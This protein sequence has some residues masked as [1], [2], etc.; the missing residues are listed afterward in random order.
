MTK[1]ASSRTHAV[2]HRW[3]SLAVRIQPSP[4]GF[5][6]NVLEQDAAISGVKFTVGIEVLRTVSGHNDAYTEV[7]SPIRT[8]YPPT[9]PS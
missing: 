5:S 2:H 1:G 9:H 7:L 6:G 4:Q 3:R 8:D